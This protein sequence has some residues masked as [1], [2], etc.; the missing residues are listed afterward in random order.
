MQKPL[1]KGCITLSKKPKHETLIDTTA[2]KDMKKGFTLTLLFSRMWCV[3]PFFKAFSKFRIPLDDCHLVILDNT[4]KKPLGDILTEVGNDLK[5]RF[6]TLRLI[7]TFRQGSRSL[8]TNPQQNFRKSKLP[9]IYEAYRDIARLV[10]TKNFINIED[11]TICPPHTIMRLLSHINTRGRD[12]FISGIEPN[13]GPDP[14]IKSRLGV[15]YIYRI[16]NLMLQRVSLSPKCQGVKEVDACGWYCFLT[17]TKVW[18]SGFK[19]MPDYLNNIPHFALDMFHTNNIKRKGY[20]VLADFRIHC[21]HIHPT[22]DKILYWRPVDAVSQ[23]DYYIPQ[24]KIWCQAQNLPYEVKDRPQ[25]ER[26]RIPAK[27]CL[28]CK[29]DSKMKIE[30]D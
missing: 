24:Y 29:P 5:E 18:R 8:R 20:P 9:F 27:I 16:N 6:Y 10:T 21:F 30:I 28:K 15:H 12:I 11:D 7:K 14:E 22:P 25:F 23:I 19:G 3:N 4:D 17:S 26:W 2:G 1:L 13:R